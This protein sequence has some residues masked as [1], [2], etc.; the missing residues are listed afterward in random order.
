MIILVSF[1]CTISAVGLA[2]SLI[3]SNEIAKSVAGLSEYLERLEIKESEHKPNEDK[4]DREGENKI[5]N[6][7]EDKSGSPSED[8]EGASSEEKQENGDSPEPDKTHEHV[9]VKTVVAP[10]CGDCGYSLY[11]CDCGEEYKDEFVSALGHDFGEWEIVKEATCFDDGEEQRICKNDQTHIEKRIIDRLSHNFVANVTSPSCESA[12]YT[13]Y[14]CS[15]CGYSYKSDIVSAL[16]HDYSGWEV[17]KEATCFDD[18]EEQR[19]CKNDQTHIE[20]RIID[21]LSHNFVASVTSP[22]CES[23]GYTTYT[24]SV[25]G[26]SYKGDPVSALGHDYS[27]WKTVRSATCEEDGEECR[28]CQNDESHFEIRI[29]PRLG[30]IFESE[31]IPPTCVDAGYTLYSCLRCEFSYKDDFLSPSGHSYEEHTSQPTCEEE[32]VVLYECSVCGDSYVLR[33]TPATG[34]DFTTEEVLPTCVEEGYTLYKC[35]N[36]GKEVKEDFIPASGHVY[37]EWSVYTNSETGESVEGRYCSV[38]GHYEIRKPENQHEHIYTSVVIAPTCE[39]SGYTR[40]TCEICGEYHD[41]NFTQPLGHNYGEWAV[42]TDAETGKTEERRYCSVCGDYE[43]REPANDH[44]PANDHEHNY[45]AVIIE[46][47]CEENGYTRYTCEICGDHFDSDITEPLGHDFGE[48]MVIKSPT[49]QEE[50]VEERTCSRD[51]GHTEIRSVEKTDHEFEVVSTVQ[52]TPDSQ[53][54]TLYR[55]KFCNI[56]EMRDQTDYVAVEND[57]FYYEVKDGKAIITGLKN[58]KLTEIVIPSAIGGYTVT[59]I[60][61]KAFENDRKIISCTLADE[62]ESIGDEAFKGC[63][64]LLSV[65]FGKNLTKI[66]MLAFKDCDLLDSVEYEGLKWKYSED[67]ETYMNPENLT[68]DGETMANYLKSEYSGYY[69]LGI[70]I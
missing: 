37:G 19:I 1:T 45:T 16:E 38:C 26:Y 17:V 60:S 7:S 28:F 5:D 54:Y 29:V 57:D 15:V 13:T 10:T 61:A 41:Y 62:I 64:N 21:R 31:I 25:C 55:C 4:S 8:R 39:E 70:K 20:K 33:R 6:V 58:Q 69:W 46:P 34:H 52:P 30:H 14:T 67:G 40:Y 12:G 66:G 44:D 24:C 35:V 51:A 32:G 49:C 48:W 2:F 47:T 42:Y 65:K 27:E 63:L 3:G 18:G 53:G 43:S 23:A 11:V 68:P 59:G 9:F 56:E 22:S 36:C 50:G